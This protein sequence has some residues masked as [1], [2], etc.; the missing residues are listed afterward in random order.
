M[1]VR[2]L[3]EDSAKPQDAVSTRLSLSPVENQSVTSKTSV[4]TP[5]TVQNDSPQSGQSGKR[6]LGAVSKIEDGGR[7]LMPTA[8]GSGTDAQKAAPAPAPSGLPP[9]PSYHAAGELDPPP[10]P[11]AD[12]EPAY[13]QAAGT[14]DGRVVIRILIAADGSVDNVAVVRSFPQGFFE[15][16]AIAAFGQAKFS[17]GMIKGVPVKSQIT[18]E[19]LYTP[20]NRG[21]AVSGAR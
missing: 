10:S 17:P 20:V 8:E 4:G 13:P 3:S 18:I 21:A 1:Q 12:I 5:V 7:K 16:S 19:V 9:A 15:D 11:L 6:D 2:V 14:R